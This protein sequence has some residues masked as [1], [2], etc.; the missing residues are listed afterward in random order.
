MLA[1]EIVPD[2]VF[3]LEVAEEGP[4]S[5]IGSIITSR[6][7]P[8]TNP[9]SL[10]QIVDFDPRFEASYRDEGDRSYSIEAFFE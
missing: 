8:E 6:R 5:A 4:E 9:T 7:I 2:G 3:D 1:S 10:D